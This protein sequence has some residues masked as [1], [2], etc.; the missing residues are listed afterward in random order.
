MFGTLLDKNVH[1][2]GTQQNQVVVRPAFFVPLS[3]P[4]PPKIERWPLVWTK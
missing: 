4:A 3:L 1:L 2:V